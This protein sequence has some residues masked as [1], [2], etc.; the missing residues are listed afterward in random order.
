MGHSV[1][2]KEEYGNIKIVLERLKYLDHQWLICVDL[3][4][5]NF[6]LGQQGGYTKYPCFLCY[7][8]STADKDHWVRMEWSSRHTLVPGQKNVINEPL[9]D[10][11]KNHPSTIAHQTR[12]YEVV[13][14]FNT[15]FQPFRVLVIRRKRQ[16]Y[17]TDTRSEH[18]QGIYISLR[19]WMLSN[20][21]RGLHLLMW[22]R[23]FLGTRKTTITKRL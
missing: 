10:R 14:V 16:G 3:K 1:S 20:L 2:M 6:L 17:S 12:Y 22:Y 19:G 18:Y 21:E 9:F 4:M 8:D 15:Y 23:V 7:W 11:K 13:I 5:V